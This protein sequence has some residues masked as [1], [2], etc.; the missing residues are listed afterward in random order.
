MCNKWILH[1]VTLCLNSWQLEAVA[2]P[3]QQCGRVAVHVVMLVW[4]EHVYCTVHQ[5]CIQS[6]FVLVVSALGT[7][8]N[9]ASVVHICNTCYD[10]YTYI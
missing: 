3:N 7:R 6:Q 2:C 5:R 10:I 1:S 8:C 4:V 9:A